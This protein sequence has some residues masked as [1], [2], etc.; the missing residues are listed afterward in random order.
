MSVPGIDVASYQ[1]TNYATAG[2]G[3]VVVKAT[4][5]TNYINPRHDAQV[6][7]GRAH[8]LVVGHYH[9]QRPG[10]PTAQAA[11]FLQHAHVQ[12]GD[13]LA[14][15]WEDTGVPDEDKD[16]FIRAVQAAA[17][18]N[19]VLLYCN[20]DF[21]LHRDH[22][23]FAGDGLWI[24]DPGVA[25]GHPRVEHSWVM[26]Q[27]S[28]AG[29]TDRDV[30]NFANVAALRTWA[31]KG[32]T[33]KPPAPAAKP[34]VDLSNLIVAA[35]TDPHAKQGHTTHPADVR[36][37]EAALKAER[38]LAA[39]YASDGSYGTK[40]IAAYAAWQRRCGYTGTAAD[41]IPGKASLTKLGS[42]HGFN[43]VA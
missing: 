16:A 33:P 18:H 12:P 19:R 10:S 42:R 13:L 27:Y 14:C 21:W 9:F 8:G 32:T 35:K 43:V 7:T 40:T 30:A 17:P 28:E 1:A 15:D 39:S 3:L 5:G 29:G 25:A 26:H 31:A 41:G 20:R 4:E 38:L 24:A 22:T 11:Y 36:L 23:S 2:L 34:H 37:V 6:A